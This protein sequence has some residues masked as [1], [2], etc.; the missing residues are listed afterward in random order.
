MVL[1]VLRETAPT[2][3]S[4]GA[5]ERTGPLGPIGD[6]AEVIDGVKVKGDLGL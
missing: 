3:E 5:G 2:S 6:D 4:A 1:I